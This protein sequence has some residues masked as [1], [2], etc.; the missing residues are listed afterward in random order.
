MDKLL[1]LVMIV[2]TL[3][4]ITNYDYGGKTLSNI[5]IYCDESCHLPKDNSNVMILDGINCV[6]DKI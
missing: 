2:Y 4:L 6:Y 1:K 3:V 5:N